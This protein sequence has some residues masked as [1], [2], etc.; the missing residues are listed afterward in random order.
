[1]DG[2]TEEEEEEEEEVVEEGDRSAWEPSAADRGLRWDDRAR[3]GLSVPIIGLGS[4][5]LQ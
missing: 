4:E 3:L 5:I 2:V 1:M